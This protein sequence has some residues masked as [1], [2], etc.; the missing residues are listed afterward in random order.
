MDSRCS[1]RSTDF[2][3]IFMKPDL[4][5]GSIIVLHIIVITALSQS[6]LSQSTDDI[7]A[8]Y[9]KA[10][11][12][13]S[14]FEQI[15]STREINEVWQNLD[16]GGVNKESNSTIEY[17]KPSRHEVI[18]KLPNLE[19]A[20]VTSPDG[21]ESK[22]YQNNKKSGMETLG[23]FFD[24]PVPSR[25]T[26][27]SLPHQIL[28][29]NRR[30]QLQYIGLENLDDTVCEVLKGPYDPFSYEI[31]KFYFNRNSKLLFAIKNDDKG[32]TTF[33]SDYRIVQGV[34]IPFSRESF[35]NDILFYRQ[36]TIEIEFN[37]SVEPSMFY[38]KE[39]NKP[40]TTKADDNSIIL[41]IED[42]DLNRVLSVWFNGKPV[43]IDLWATWCAPCKVEFT[44]YDTTFYRTLEKLNVELLFISI[45]D[46]KKEKKWRQDIETFRLNGKHIRAGPVLVKSIKQEVFLN[47]V[48]SIPRYVVVDAW[49]QIL[50]ADFK[51][52]SVPDFAQELKKLLETR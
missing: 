27:L 38:Y 37:V 41:N 11:G 26:I 21:S 6:V 12:G 28:A 14:A 52:P 17:A 7:V 51:K 29:L 20:K 9:L 22:F 15:Y 43:F 30:K 45:D 2:V 48:I 1:E 13:V 32:T 16:L 35:N 36:R 40:V 42:I 4:I 23:M 18:R 33:F 39:A 5:P 50:S 19:V 47:G 10:S 24:N 8:N 46:K 31:V 25:Y 49:G 34:K 44:K 3:V